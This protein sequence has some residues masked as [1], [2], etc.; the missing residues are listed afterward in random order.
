MNAVL[1][2]SYNDQARLNNALLKLDVQWGKSRYKDIITEDWQGTTSNGLNVTVLS[3]RKMCRQTCNRRFKEG[4]YVWHK[5]G[6]GTGGKMR[7][8]EQGGV[9]FLRKDWED[10]SGQSTVTGM[11]W[12]RYISKR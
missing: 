7:Y 10:A 6:S 3:A 2:N 11:D 5:G 12:L 9:W 1:P 8:A 4:Y